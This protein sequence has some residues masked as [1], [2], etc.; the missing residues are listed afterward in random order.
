MND[1]NTVNDVFIYAFLLVLIIVGCQ[2]LYSENR[3]IIN[4]IIM[5]VH[6]ALLYPFS[7]INNSNAQKLINHFQ[8]DNPL[9]YDW[10]DMLILSSQSGRYWRWI[11]MPIM[12]YWSYWAIT[13]SSVLAIYQRRLSMRE[14][15]QNNV[16]QF[17][18]MAP[19]AKVDIL[20]LPLHSGPWRFLQQP[21]QFAALNQLILDKN[22]QP[23]PQDWL[24][25]PKTLLPNDESPL[26]TKK[27]IAG[28]HL[29]R[30]KATRLIEAQLGDPFRGV[31]KLPGHIKGLAAAFMAF[32][33]GDKKAGQAMMDKMSS[34]YQCDSTG[35]FKGIDIS[36]CD[37]LLYRFANDGLVIK[38]TQHHT[39]FI[40]TWM[41]A[42]L[43]FARKKGV[44]A[45]SQF[46]WLRPT[47]HQLF[48]TLDQVGY[49][50]PWSSAIG[51]WVHF[52]Y[53]RLA[54]QSI[55]KPDCAR[56]ANDFARELADLGFI[57]EKTVDPIDY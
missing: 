24:I 50:L 17:P 12:M 37:D 11:F 25:N 53:E 56:A 6:K 26:L 23:I 8:W 39:A 57:D 44:L 47:D 29:D 40:S 45:V 2:F 21:L 30:E 46:I 55:Y 19:I 5:N 20:N 48:C 27:G 51:P 34:T 52:D 43:I 3:E 18:C 7:L 15:V 13:K 31:D 1:K 10:N 28:V 33:V 49:K 32:G 38:A 42:L 41:V 9:R 22:N 14:L 16:E 54:E 36:G 35:K 4:L